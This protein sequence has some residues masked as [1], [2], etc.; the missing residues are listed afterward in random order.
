MPLAV[1]LRWSCKTSRAYLHT[2]SINRQNSLTNPAM[3]SA[4][5]ILP[6]SELK[7]WCLMVKTELQARRTGHW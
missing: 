5:C 6:T 7:P 4:K 2:L 1:G 3:P